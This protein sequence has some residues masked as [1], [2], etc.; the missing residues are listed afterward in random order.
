MEKGMSVDPDQNDTSMQELEDAL[1][2][3]LEEQKPQ[4]EQNTATS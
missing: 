4:P 1:K 3:W 2:E